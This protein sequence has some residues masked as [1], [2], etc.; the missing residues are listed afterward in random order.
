MPDP[1]EARIRAEIIE[2][3][4]G[5]F[6]VPL[7]MLPPV[8]HYPI[9]RNIGY[10]QD[11][12]TEYEEICVCGTCVPKHSHFASRAAVPEWPCPYVPEENTMSWQIQA[13]GHI[14]VDANDSTADAAALESELAA[15]IG[16]ILAE[17]K[18]G[19]TTSRVDG[20][21]IVGTVHTGDI[22]ARPAEPAV[23][24]TGETRHRPA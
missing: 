5:A 24:R 21:H 3:A 4:A 2:A 19:C 23:H 22:H 6:N 11:G 10:G 20:N 17:P 9:W 7:D 14:R 12:D 13:S 18:Y 1:R 8:P 15:R 16:E